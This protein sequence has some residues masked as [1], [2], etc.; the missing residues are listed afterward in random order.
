MKLALL[1]ASTLLATTALLGQSLAQSASQTQPSSKMTFAM[2]APGAGC[3]VSM[4]ALHGSGYGL[5]AVKNQPP[6]KGF[7][8]QIH[9]ILGNGQTAKVVSA[10]VFVQGYSGKTRVEQTSFNEVGDLNRTI[11]VSFT[12]E[13]DAV[14]ADLV[15]PGFAAVSSIR[16]QSIAY[17]DG[18]IWKVSGEQMCRVTPDPLMLVSSEAAQ[19]RK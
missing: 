10:K 18:S 8:A 11:D 2:P 4:H 1:T 15:L 17:N 16:L 12:P 5:I 7:S 6:V 14:A 19:K 9:L 13:D 3:P